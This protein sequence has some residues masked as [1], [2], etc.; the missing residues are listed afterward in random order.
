MTRRLT[1]IG[2]C[3]AMLFAACSSSS[4]NGSS[5]A[6]G[7][8]YV[9]AMVAGFNKDKAKD[10]SNPLTADQAKCLSRKMVDEL[11]VDGLKK[12]GVTT[13]NL[14]GANGLDA[15]GKKLTKDQA[16]KVAEVF[17]GG[18]CFDMAKLLAA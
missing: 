10:P 5:S 9:A 11:G 13:A 8:K 17:F 7:E 16:A 15:M 2:L 12:A 3:A 1:M 18:S 14:S 6:E 4:S